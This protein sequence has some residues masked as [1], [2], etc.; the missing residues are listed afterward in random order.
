MSDLLVKLYTLPESYP[1]EKQLQLQNIEV[2]HAIAPEKTV[3]CHW[4]REHFS[5]NWHDECEVAFA[6]QPTRCLLA[7]AL[8]ELVGFACYDVTAKGFFGPTGVHPNFR[9][10]QI[11]KLLLLKSLEALRSEGYGYAIIGG[12]GPT[13]F[14]AKTVGA[15]EIPDSSPGVY[16]GML[17]PKL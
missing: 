6:F 1:L 13:E 5:L 17:K 15:M 9:G 8:G 2:R 3:V 7:V 10:K 12:V 4:V 14:Y 11:G 16:R